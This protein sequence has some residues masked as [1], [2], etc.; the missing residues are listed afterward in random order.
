MAGLGL[1]L[2]TLLRR[3][4]LTHDISACVYAGVVSA[5]PL[6]LSILGILLIGLLSLGTVRPLALIV[7]FQVSVTYLI[8]ASLILTGLVQLLFT[9]FLSDR[10]FEGQAN[11]VLANYNGL[12]MIT[13]CVAGAIGLALAATAFKHESAGYRVLMLMGFVILGNIWICTIF[14]ASLKRFLAILVSFFIGY[15]ITVTAA[16]ALNHMGLEGLLAGFV[17]GHLALLASMTFML[18]RLRMFDGSSYV[19]WE[20]FNPQYAYFSLMLVGLLFNLGVWLDKFMFWFSSAGQ[21]VIGPL[22]ASVIYDLPIFIAY[23]CIIP[24]MAVFMLRLETDFVEHYNGYFGAIR[25]GRPLSDIRETREMMVHSARMGLYEILKIQTVVTLMVFAFGDVLL[26][27]IGISTLY[28]PLL[29]IDVIAAGLQVLFL[30]CLNIFMYLDRRR[31]VLALTALFVALNGVFTWITLQIGP[32]AYGYG[33]A[34]ALLIAVF[35]A[36]IVLNRSFAR[37]E[38]ETYMLQAA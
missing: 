31:I 15:T 14:L 33:F 28:F 2:R 37:L 38:Y 17:V 19:L 16:L 20:V 5:G 23:L 3:D 30:A 24:G 10:L 6:I 12:M 29:R 35:V 7:Q 22:R 25:E 8:A 1:Q 36:I 11:R 27:A 18:R 21:D 34:A 32:K 9:R 26:R 13:T 4:T